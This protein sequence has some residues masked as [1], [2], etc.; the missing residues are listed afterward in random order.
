MAVAKG[1][2]D[3][4]ISTAASMCSRTTKRVERAVEVMRGAG[5]AVGAWFADPPPEQAAMAAA[6]LERRKESQRL[7]GRC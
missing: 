6:P 4:C 5:P 2:P 7:M 1:S 3:S